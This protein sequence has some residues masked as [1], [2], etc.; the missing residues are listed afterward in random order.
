MT[1]PFAESGS[2]QVSFGVTH[3][4]W[5][6]S[7]AMRI[8]SGRHVLIVSQSEIGQRPVASHGAVVIEY[9]VPRESR[10]S[11]IRIERRRYLKSPCVS[12]DAV[13]E[14]DGRQLDVR[15]HQV[16][17]AVAE[18]DHCQA[19]RRRDLR[20]RHPLDVENPCAINGVRRRI[21]D[22]ALTG[23]ELAVRKLASVIFRALERLRAPG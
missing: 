13:F 8:R 9:D 20:F 22:L 18:D 1:T 5:T 15:E 6:M 3:R 17:A 21:Q 7:G 2:E 23:H 10:G 12:V 16:L 4:T 14:R 11:R 19:S